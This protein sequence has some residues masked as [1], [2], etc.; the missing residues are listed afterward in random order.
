MAVVYGDIIL[1]SISQVAE[2]D[3]FW[4]EGKTGEVIQLTLTDLDPD[5]Y[6]APVA[7][8]FDPTLTEIGTLG[9]SNGRGTVLE[10]AL[11]KTGTYRVVVREYENNET[12]P[13]G[14]GLQRLA[15]TLPD[16]L[17]LCVGCVHLNAVDPIADSDVF[18]F[19]GTAGDTIQLTLTDLDPD[20]YHA[21]VAQVFDPTLTEIG[22]LGWSNGR[23]TVLE[24]ALTKTGTYR[25][26]VREYENNE[27]APYRLGLQCIGGPC[28]LAPPPPTCAGH[29][30]TI[31]GTSGPNVIIGTSGADVIVGLGGDD[32]IHGAGGNDVICGESGNDTIYGNDGNDQVYGEAGNDTVRGDNG[33]DTLRGGTGNDTVNGGAGNDRVFGEAG[34]DTLDGGSNDDEINGGSG[35]DICDGN[36]GLDTPSTSTC[37]FLLNIP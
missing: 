17:A 22:T 32:V 25:V 5:Y 29:V 13:Y 37:E 2:S 26:V 10:L 31:I 30:A 20:Y 27:T 16:A 19:G 35:T 6:H 9:W 8:V 34:N 14:L 28:F 21:P 12:A 1:C 36:V 3:V 4:F 24:L 7:Q 23:G 15:P 18:I 33:A 11:T